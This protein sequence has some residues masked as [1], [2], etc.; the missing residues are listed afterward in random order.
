MLT[1]NQRRLVNYLLGSFERVVIEPLLDLRSININ[2]VFLIGPPRSGTTVIYRWF[3]H[4][5]KNKPAYI[6]RLTDLYPESSYLLNLIGSKIY[7]NNLQIDSLHEYGQ[8][9]GFTS[10]A[11]GNRLWPWVFD[12][13][14]HSERIKTRHL[15]DRTDYNKSRSIS[16]D[17]YNFL[18]RVLRKQCLLMKSEL[19]INKSVHNTIRIVELKKLFPSAKFISII[20]D[21]RS[22]T[23]S[24]MR[25]RVDIQGD[26][27]KWWGVR[28][29]NWDVIHSLPPHLSCGKQW[30]GLLNDMED[31]LSHISKT[32]Y[33][34]I[35][36]EDFLTNPY[37]EL[38]KIYDHLDLNFEFAIKNLTNLK[39]PKDYQDFFNDRELKELNEM[40]YKKLD[41]WNY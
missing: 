20:R 33:I 37:E 10:L 32:D 5:L 23:K 39:T 11:E 41:Q 14:D 8:V 9:K 26:L 29:S 25:A 38:E 19:L 21:G 40:I 34:F 22:V 31:Q 3:V 12:S 6:S 17:V 16:P 28:P 2:P 35:R 4:Y 27:N 1:H 36:F 13:L 24:L 15:F 18:H 30:E 7:G